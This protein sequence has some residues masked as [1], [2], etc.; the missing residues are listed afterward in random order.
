MMLTFSMRVMKIL[1]LQIRFGRNDEPTILFS[2]AKLFAELHLS[3][4]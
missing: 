2:L 1:K 4:Y 3:D